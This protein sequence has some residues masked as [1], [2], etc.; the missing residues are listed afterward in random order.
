VWL[1]ERLLVATMGARRCTECGAEL[2]LRP[3]EC[4][5][6]GSDASPKAARPLGTDVETYQGDVRRLREQLRKLREDAEAV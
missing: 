6:C 1:D 5:L 3:S 4:P 2:N